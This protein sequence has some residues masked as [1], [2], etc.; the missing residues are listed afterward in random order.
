M[1]AAKSKATRGKKAPKS[2]GAAG[3]GYAK[4][5]ETRRRVLAAA[6]Q[7]FGEDG[8]TGASTRRIAQASGVTLP[9]LQYYFGS[10]EGLYRACAET[11]VDRYNEHT[12]GPAAA[13]AA[14]IAAGC[15]ADTAR[16][17]LKQVIAALTVVMV[18]SKQAGNWT[19]FAAREVR[20]PGAAFELLYER[21]WA[22]GLQIVVGLLARIRGT[23]PTDTA[24]RAQAILLI[25][26]L[27]AFGSGR[28]AAMRALGWSTV[29][30]R[31][32]K[33]IVA[34]LDAQIDTMN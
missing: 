7:A 25:S 18:E 5:E 28:K 13:A 11:I 16:A 10:K 31:E 15:D 17:H 8:F 12:A 20:D 34:A 3:S 29:G 9:V 4:S 6:L 23:P 14:A 19:P 21:L 1:P 2:Q 32:L 30:P 33:T 24:I 27:S 26:S 22:P